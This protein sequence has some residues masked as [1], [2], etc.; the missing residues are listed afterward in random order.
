[1]PL[2]EDWRVHYNQIHPHIGLQGRT[3]CEVAGVTTTGG[4]A[5]WTLFYLAS[6]TTQ[7]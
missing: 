6:W 2:S 3:P 4:I 1:M 5:W 7:E